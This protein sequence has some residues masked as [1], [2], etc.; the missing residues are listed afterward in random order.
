[1][2]IVVQ[3]VLALTVVAL[4]GSAAVAINR[5]ARG[6]SQLDRSIAS[7]LLVATV[8]GG[9]GVWAISSRQDTEIVGVLLLSV[10]G[11]TGA[12]AIARMVGERV[13]LRRAREARDAVEE[14]ER[15]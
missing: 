13:I 12:V 15:P 5:I 7:D 4:A 11:F 14:G 1:M 2:N 8:I 10:V 9:I 3:V 6:P